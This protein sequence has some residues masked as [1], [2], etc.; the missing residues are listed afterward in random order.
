MAIA[1]VHNVDDAVTGGTCKGC[2][3]ML[4][5]SENPAGNGLL[6]A[7]GAAVVAAAGAAAGGL[8]VPMLKNSGPAE[9]GTRK[10]RQSR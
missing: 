6:M 3:M 7:A 1:E 2:I 9:R 10:I 4:G 8:G 5:M